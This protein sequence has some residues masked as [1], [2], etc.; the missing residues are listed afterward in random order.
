MSLV[1]ALRDGC[2]PVARRPAVP[3]HRR[4][5]RNR[6][7]D[8]AGR[9]P[10]G[11]EARCD[12]RQHGGARCRGPRARRRGRGAPGHHITDF[13]AVRAFAEEVH[14]THGSLDVVANVAGIS[15]W[16]AVE[17]LTQAQWRRSIDVD[18]LGPVHV[19]ASFVPEMVR[20]GSGGQLV[21][22]SSAAG[23][24]GLPRHAPYSAA[25]FGLRGI[26]EVLRFDLRA[27][28]IGVTLVSRR[29]PHTAGW[30]ARHRGHRPRGAPGERLAGALPPP[31]QDAGAGGR[32]DPRRRGS[33]PLSR[34][35]VERRSR[36]P[37]ARALAS[38]RIPTGDARGHRPPRDGAREAHVA[39]RRRS[40]TRS[41]RRSVKRSGGTRSALS[42]MA[43]SS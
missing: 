27:H 39:Q 35:H 25:K 18:L 13:E 6:P 12:G 16:G 33:Q 19:I 37:P 41:A 5:Q 2:P 4:G 40:G 28:R 14:G 34:L 10:C 17:R 21:N 1:S 42:V 29:G 20:T 31:R 7:R 8:R 38:A 26:S 22:F 15:T 23:L 9:A 3:R 32:A 11:R 36:A 30:N 43:S 24:L